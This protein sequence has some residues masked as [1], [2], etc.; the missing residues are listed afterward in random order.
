M[1]CLRISWPGG[2]FCNV[3]HSI[4]YDGML[5]EEAWQDLL[6]LNSFLTG[7]GIAGIEQA[8]LQHVLEDTVLMSRREIRG[9]FTT[10]P[11]LAEFLCQISV[12]D[13]T[14][15]CMDTCSGHRHHRACAAKPEAEARNRC[16][17]CLWDNL[18]IR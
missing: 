15:H 3:F 8:D 12:E 13:W 11:P 5:P 14:G 4:P 18:D 17:R 7:N 9:Q 6:E 1:K 2:D 16:C 10:P